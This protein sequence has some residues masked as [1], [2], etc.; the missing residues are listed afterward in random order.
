MSEMTKMMLVSNYV[1]GGGVKRTWGNEITG[2]EV[3]ENLET[4]NENE[5]RA[6]SYT[7]YGEAGLKLRKGW[8]WIYAWLEHTA[9]RYLLGGGSSSEDV[10]CGQYPE[11]WTHDLRLYD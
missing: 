1:K 8:L 7:P 11:P 2:V 9:K 5:D 3:P 4:I 10:S 6:P